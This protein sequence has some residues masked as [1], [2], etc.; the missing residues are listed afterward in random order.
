M[1]KTTTAAISIVLLTATFALADWWDDFKNFFL[2]VG[3][4]QAVVEVLKVGVQPNDIMGEGLKFEGLNP[5]NLVKAMYCGGIRGNDI[6][7]AAQTHDVSDLIVV[8]GYK[9]SVEECG[10][11]VVDT[12]AYT[13]VATT[14][15]F[16]GQA[17]TNGT[18]SDFAS[19]SNFTS[20]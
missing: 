6:R 1:I 7:A 15:S 8:A 10:D 2:D 4:D 9:K 13:P 12:Q 18:F 19:K 14:V 17:T 11:K 20:P 3:I 5:Q 16:A